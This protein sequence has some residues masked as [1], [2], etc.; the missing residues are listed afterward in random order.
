MQQA[1][2]PLQFQSNPVVKCIAY[3]SLD[4]TIAYKKSK[5]RTE[6]DGIF[7]YK[8][9]HEIQYKYKY[10]CHMYIHVLHKRV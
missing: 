3:T 7:L 2:Q 5:S 1:L 10:T 8:A 6:G 9:V 4:K